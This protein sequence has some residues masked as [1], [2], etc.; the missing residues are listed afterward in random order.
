MK[1]PG[2]TKLDVPSRESTR[3][4]GVDVGAEA[5]VGSLVVVD[6]KLIED[7]DTAVIDETVV[8]VVWIEE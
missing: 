6:R 8:A 4:L 1:M 2:W 5:E 3:V 7:D